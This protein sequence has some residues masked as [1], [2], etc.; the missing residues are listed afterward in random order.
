[1]GLSRAGARKGC[2]PLTLSSDGPSALFFSRFLLAGS[3]PGL[4]ILGK[5]ASPLRKSPAFSLGNASEDLGGTPS[6]EWEH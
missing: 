1:M 5:M 4:S 3:M 2:L 6:E